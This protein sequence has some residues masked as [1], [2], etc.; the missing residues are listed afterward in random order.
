MELLNGIFSQVCGCNPSSLLRLDKGE[1][2]YYSEP[3]SFFSGLPFA[4]EDKLPDLPNDEGQDEDESEGDSYC[5]ALP[6]IS[7]LPFATE[8]KLPELPDEKGK[9]QDKGE[10][11]NDCQILPFNFW[12]TYTFFNGE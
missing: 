10:D 12:L 5:E 4:K 8:N 9:G 2:A 7:N 3:V 1:E 11:A 6:L